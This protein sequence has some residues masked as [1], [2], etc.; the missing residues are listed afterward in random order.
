MVRVG[1]KPQLAGLCCI[2]LPFSELYSCCASELGLDFQAD[3]V[4]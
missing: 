3:E 2:S 1:F 4:F